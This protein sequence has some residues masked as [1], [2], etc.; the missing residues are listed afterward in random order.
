MMMFFG[1]RESSCLVFMFLRTRTT[2]FERRTREWCKQGRGL[3]AVRGDEFHFDGSA[4]VARLVHLGNHGDGRYY[5]RAWGV[6]RL[7]AWGVGRRLS[8]GWFSFRSFTVSFFLRAANEMND[9]V[10]KS[11]RFA[12]SKRRHTNIR[13]LKSKYRLLVVPAPARERR[14]LDSLLLLHSPNLCININNGRRSF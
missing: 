11:S 5:T 14:L 13:S 1:I 2:G 4:W 10:G 12:K 6:G 8:S 9:R 7:R 3:E